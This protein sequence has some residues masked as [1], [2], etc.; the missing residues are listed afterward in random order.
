M[1]H[2]LF[3]VFIGLFITNSS[4]SP[5]GL[6]MGMS[7]KEITAV[8]TAK[9]EKLDK[10]IYVIQPKKSHPQFKTYLAYVDKKKGLYQIRAVSPTIKTN[11]YGTELQNHFYDI[12]NRISKTYGE[13]I[14]RNEINENSPFQGDEYWLHTL[15]DGARTLAAIWG[16]DSKLDENLDLI[17]LECGVDNSLF[18]GPYLILFYYF[19]NSDG[20][21]DDID[22]VF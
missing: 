15:K 2:I 14:I 5:F 20:V 9:P 13:P 7:L 19:K 4:A 1:K 11:P 22:S 21:E 8:S 10:G 3:I 12:K 17:V 16:K 18:G 6:K